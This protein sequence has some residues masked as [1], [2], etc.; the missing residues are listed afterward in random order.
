[1]KRYLLVTISILAAFMAVS[2][3]FASSDD[4]EMAVVNFLVLK[5]NNGKPLRNASVV[6]HPVEKNG[7]QSRGGLELK[8]DADGKA[9][10]DGV[11]YGKLRIQVLAPGFQTFGEDFDIAKPVEAITVK[12]KRPTEQYSIYKDNQNDKKED[13]PKEETPKEQPK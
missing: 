3:G 12:M 1:M 7:K 2:T 4:E 5:D 6:M 8:C 13:P 11:P 9:S 10:F